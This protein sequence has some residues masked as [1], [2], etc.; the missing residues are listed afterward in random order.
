MDGLWSLAEKLQHP[1]AQVVDYLQLS[2]EAGLLHTDKQGV[3]VMCRRKLQWTVLSTLS[4]FTVGP[5]RKVLPSLILTDGGFSI[6]MGLT[7][8]SGIHHSGFP[9]LCKVSLYKY[10]SPNNL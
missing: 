4:A 2:N 1:K 6:L 3:S 8:D 7:V 9:L 5:E 10:D